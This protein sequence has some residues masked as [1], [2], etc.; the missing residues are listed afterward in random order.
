MTPIPNTFCYSPPD[1][2]LCRKFINDFCDATKPSKSEAGGAVCGVLTFQIN[3]FDMSS[4]N[5]DLNV[6]NTAT[7]D[8]LKK[9]ENLNLMGR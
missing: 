8:L 7:L 2:S 6:L 9:K 5:I 3:L 4:L 1:V